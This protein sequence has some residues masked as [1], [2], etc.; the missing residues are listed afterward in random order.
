[1]VAI[2]TV[3]E[4]AQ[5]N[6]ISVLL[7]VCS[8]FDAIRMKRQ[9]TDMSMS[10][11]ISVFFMVRLLSVACRISGSKTKTIAHYGVAASPL[12]HQILVVEV[13]VYQHQC[14]VIAPI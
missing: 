1:M 4:L 6:V 12:T 9:M 10:R 14:D 7:V 13:M 2:S 11:S 3:K 8:Q 5:M